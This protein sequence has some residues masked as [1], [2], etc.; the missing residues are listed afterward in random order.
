METKSYGIPFAR[1]WCY[2]KKYKILKPVRKINLEGVF[3]LKRGPK[4]GQGEA[5]GR[6][7]ETKERPGE[8]KGGQSSPKTKNDKKKQ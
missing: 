1:E 4:G 7:K 6:Q 8:A 2:K 5:K 3:L